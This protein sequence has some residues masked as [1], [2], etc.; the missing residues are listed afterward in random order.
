MSSLRQCMPPLELEERGICTL[1][2]VIFT[3]GSRVRR[4]TGKVKL[5]MGLM[6]VIYYGNRTDDKF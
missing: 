2:A 3:I 5:Y 1:D 6:G 4:K